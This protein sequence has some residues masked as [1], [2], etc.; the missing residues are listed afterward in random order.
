[1]RSVFLATVI[2]LLGAPIS[3]ADEQPVPL[4][5]ALGIDRGRLDQGVGQYR[6]NDWPAILQVV[7]G[8]SRACAASQHTV[9]TRAASSAPRSSA[10]Q[11]SGF[12][13]RE[14]TRFSRKFSLPP[15]KSRR[16]SRVRS[17]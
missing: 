10:P 1:M 15:A 7:N 6:S 3:Y 2:E 11:E 16:S 9:S 8:P 5:D 4:K 14:P 12:S 13:S 17:R